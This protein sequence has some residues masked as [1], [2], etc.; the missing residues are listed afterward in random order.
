MPAHI[1]IQG[2]KFTNT[3]NI[4]QWI[5]SRTG[6]PVL[7][8]N[9]LIQRAGDRF[10]MGAD[11]IE[12]A[13]RRGDRPTRRAE[14]Q[15]KKAVACLKSALAE[16]LRAEAGI[17]SGMAGH[18]IPSEMPHVLRVLVTASSADRIR[19]ASRE[20]NVIE[21]DARRQIGKTDYQAFQRHRHFTG[22]SG[23]RAASYDV[24]V[25]TEVLDT[26]AAAHLI[27][28]HLS[29]KASAAP[30]DVAKALDDFR[31]AAEVQLAM[32]RKG[33]DITAAASSGDV[34]LTIDRKVIRLGEMTEKLKRMV[35]AM[36]NV[37]AVEVTV[38][39]DFHQAD[40]VRCAR[41]EM[42]PAMAFEGYAGNRRQLRRS[43][44][45]SLPPELQR[46]PEKTVGVGRP[47]TL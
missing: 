20:R 4:V 19:R 44:A 7:T 33:Y 36:P 8:D 16:T 18:L 6:W 46:R 12:R 42:S 1:F 37:A 28:E 47:L 38:G 17:I 21:K 11:R 5:A 40:I 30:D 26:E 22:T 39:G 27:L 24:V 25:P 32:A 31:L 41:F 34:K 43:A 3:G 23:A 13:L 14:H 9:D 2:E 35:G 45:R 10:G 29:E 15:R